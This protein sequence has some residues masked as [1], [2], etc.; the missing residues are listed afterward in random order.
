LRAR[1]L[2]T[3]ALILS[4]APAAAQSVQLSQPQ[5]A[6]PRRPVIEARD[7]PYP[8]VLALE[9]D[10]SDTRRGIFKVRQTVPV[11]GPGT[12]TLRYPQ[13]L[14]GNHGP[15][16]PI[17]A[18][19]GLTF[20]S[21]NRVLTWRRNPEDVFA[22]DVDVPAGVRSV[23]ARFDYLSDQPG[24]IGR[25]E[26]TGSLINLQWEKMSLYPAGHFVRQIRIRPTVILPEGW[27]GVSAIDGEPRRGRVTYA[28]PHMRRWWTAP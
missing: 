7:V 5:A 12:L 11:A 23:E 17:E 20:S 9:V 15:T 25:T 21:G 14:P 22:F 10:A 16:G 18:V 2:L 6:V 3:A 27:T 24:D 19:A 8:G 26:M 13:W 28:K 1:F 4:A